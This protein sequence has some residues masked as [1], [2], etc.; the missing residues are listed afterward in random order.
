[1]ELTFEDLKALED[2][3]V[4]ADEAATALR[5]AVVE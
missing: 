3:A 1:M 5:A 4:R 2:V